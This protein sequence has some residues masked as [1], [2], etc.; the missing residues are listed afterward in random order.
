MKAR[1][2]EEKQMT[3]IR[4]HG[5]QYYSFFLFG[6]G[7]M[8]ADYFHVDTMIAVF[9]QV[10]PAKFRNRWEGKEMMQLLKIRKLREQQYEAPDFT[11]KDINNNTISLRQYRNK[12]VLINFWATW[13]VP[14]VQEFPAL[15]KITANIP[16]DKL[17]RIFI[18]QDKEMAVLEK[19]MKKYDLTGIHLFAD[20]QLIKKYKA[21]AIPQ[22]YLIDKEGKIIYDRDEL[23]DYDLEQLSVVV[24]KVLGQH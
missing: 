14:C 10:F 20:S 19:S 1:I 9:N 2:L 16:E 21:A 24:Q 11:A 3:Y 6:Q 18:T 7:L 12:Y 4:D 17:V 13:C 23:R 15:N 8:L 22:V 5:S